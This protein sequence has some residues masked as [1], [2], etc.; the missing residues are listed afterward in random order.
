MLK[1]PSPGF[2]HPADP[3]NNRSNDFPEWFS[4]FFQQKVIILGAARQGETLNRENGSGTIRR[5][6][7][8]ETGPA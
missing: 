5:E 3:A 2:R 4:R 1:A 6:F 7:L 8:P